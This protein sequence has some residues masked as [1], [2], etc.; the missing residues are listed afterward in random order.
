[1]SFGFSVGDFHAIV[2][3]ATKTRKTFVDAPAHFRAISNEVKSLSY[4]LRDVE[5]D[6]TDALDIDG[7]DKL[8]NI[9]DG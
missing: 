8:E 1:M 3:L 4:L 5:A 7:A 9:V 2:E 6:V